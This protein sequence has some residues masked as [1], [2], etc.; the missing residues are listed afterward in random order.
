MRRRRSSPAEY[1]TGRYIF[2]KYRGCTVKILLTIHDNYAKFI[3]EIVTGLFFMHL[4]GLLFM[5][6]HAEVTYNAYKNYIIL[7]R[8]QAA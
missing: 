1:G 5:K 2:C 8:V 7:H 4:N 6:I 3:F